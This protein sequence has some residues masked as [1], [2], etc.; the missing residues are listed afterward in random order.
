M[1][2]QRLRIFKTRQARECC[3]HNDK[4]INISWHNVLVYDLVWRP[5]RYS[6]RRLTIIASATYTCQNTRSDKLK[7]KKSPYPGQKFPLISRHAYGWHKEPGKQAS[8]C[9]SHVFALFGWQLDHYPQEC[10][11]S[12][13]EMPKSGRAVWVRESDHPSWFI[14]FSAGCATPRMARSN[15]RPIF[16]NGVISA[17]LLGL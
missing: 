13:N 17:P 7:H 3:I 6:W 9:I 4:C 8:R 14:F 16:Y 10:H 1:Y 12:T 2:V 15:F 11:L 5:E